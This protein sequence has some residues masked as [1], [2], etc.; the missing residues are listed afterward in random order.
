MEAMTGPSAMVRLIAILAI[1]GLVLSPIGRP[2]MAMPSDMHASLDGATA[3]AQAGAAAM[4]AEMPCC[5]DKSP[6]PDCGKDC[7]CM[8]L[9]AAKT[10]N[11]VR[12]ASLFIPQRL[13][14][15]VVPGNEAELGSLAQTPPT[16]PPKI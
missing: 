6:G 16:R 1:A 9:C 5:P 8:A 13:V 4:P 15:I 2:V 10:L 12:L 3:M 11:S 14:S 7:P